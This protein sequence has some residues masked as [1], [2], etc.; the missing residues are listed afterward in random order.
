VS[1]VFRALEKAEKEKQERLKKD[2]ALVLV[3]EA[4]LPKKEEVV[5]RREKR[6]IEEPALRPE[7]SRILRP[8]PDSFS[9]EQF[10]K[11]KTQIFH[12]STNHPHTI[13]ITSANPN[14]GKTMVSFNLATAIA[15]EIQKKAILVLADLR[16]PVIPFSFPQKA[17]GLSNYLTDGIPISE[18]IIHVEEGKL[19]VIPSG[20][21]SRQSSELI[22]SDRMKQLLISLRALGEDTYIII[23]SPPI[24]STAEPTVL[25]KMVD[26]VILVVTADRTSRESVQRA[27]KLIDRDKIIGVVLNQVDLKGP[28]YYSK[29]HYGHYGKK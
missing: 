18:I 19:L 13:L 27:V 3:E 7:A 8:P 23:D 5:P 17:K 11:V 29:Y 4:S 21:A 26:G 22:G 1:R 6:T 16:K 25:S 15:Q 24:L 14:E 12:W 28:G 2:S 9:E 20:P 10:R